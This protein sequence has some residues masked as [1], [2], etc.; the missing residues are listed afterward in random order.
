MTTADVVAKG[1]RLLNVGIVG[2]GIAGTAAAL[3]LARRGHRVTLFEQTGHVGPIG[4][5]VLLQPSGQRVLDGMGLL[6]SL[7]PK[8]EPIE[9]IHAVTETGRDLVRLKYGD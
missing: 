7:L 9:E 3:M 2:C 1:H 6:Q 5:G 8:V 4:A